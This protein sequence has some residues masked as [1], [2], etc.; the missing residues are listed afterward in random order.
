MELVQG[1]TMGMEETNKGEGRKQEKTKTL[2]QPIN[3][4][5]L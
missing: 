2:N 5:T 3:N 4:S 1:I